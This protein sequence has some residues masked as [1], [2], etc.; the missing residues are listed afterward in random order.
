MLD[1]N[2]I[3]K[4]EIVRLGRVIEGFYRDGD[5]IHNDTDCDLMV[6]GERSKSG[7]CRRHLTLTMKS[8]ETKRCHV[9]LHVLVYLLK[10]RLNT[11]PEGLEVSHLCH[12]TNCLNVLHLRA[13]TRSV[14]MRRKRCNEDGVCYP[15]SH[16]GADD[17]IF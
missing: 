13:E 3:E 10:N 14:N 11:M 15:Q 9:Y 8:G 16:E 1:L 7:Y 12:Q 4:T 2:T 5:I 6:K 17:C